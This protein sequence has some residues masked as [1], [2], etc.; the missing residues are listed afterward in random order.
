MDAKMAAAVR[1]VRGMTN[2]YMI[3]PATAETYRR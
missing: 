3:I 1:R 2:D